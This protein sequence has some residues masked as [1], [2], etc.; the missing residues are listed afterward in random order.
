ML[1]GRAGSPA[2]AK[3]LPE[4]APASAG[5][6][7]E[8]L[9]RIGA[10]M[11][12]LIDEG[13]APGFLTA[14][15]RDARI[16]HFETHGQ[17]NI[18]AKAP[19]TR[20]TI[21]R[22]M[23]MTKP[24]VSTAAMMLVEEGR[25]R[26][27]DPVARFFP[28]FAKSRL[29]VS[30]EGE[31]METQPARRQVQIRNLL[32]HTSGYAYGFGRDPVAKLHVAR[33]V[34]PQAHKTLS[35]FVA[36]AAELP[37]RFEPGTKWEYG[38]S[39]DLLGAVVEAAADK[40]L[41]EVLQERILGP[42]GM[43]DTAFFVPPDKLSRFAASYRRKDG[44]FEVVDE[45]AKSQFL[46]PPTAPSGGGGLVGTADDY[47]RFASM[48][49]NE[50]ELDGVRILAPQTVGLMRANH[51]G[52]EAMAAREAGFGLGFGVEMTPSARNLYGGA[53]TYYWSGVN[54]TFFW[55]D[56]SNRIV[57]LLMAQ[58]DPYNELFEDE[59]RALVYQALM[60]G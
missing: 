18:G 2:L 14:I 44:A 53:G 56:P 12:R 13:E 47:L 24:I 58:M 11:N 33:N 4:V 52:K 55:V 35:D 46:K 32:T 50:G 31:T 45:P 20:D 25:M 57:G 21:F 37:L 7:L 27:T 40:P 26:L 1:L 42:L 23:S 16:V 49:L 51:L 38:I 17:R 19:M 6:D 48:L 15:V 39:T 30:G 5:F 34:Y 22:L 29:Y 3:P 36:A 60:N 9:K 8:R 43:T 54:R 28:S 59:Y 10:A 41:A